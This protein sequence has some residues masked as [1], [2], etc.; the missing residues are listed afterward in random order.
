MPD[1]LVDLLRR[2]FTAVHDVLSSSVKTAV[3]ASA[4]VP[5]VCEL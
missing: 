1:V 4:Y 2:P 5:N 3:F